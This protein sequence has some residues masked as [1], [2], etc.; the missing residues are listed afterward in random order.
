M[1]QYT[2]EWFPA[3]LRDESGEE[4]ASGR[5]CFNAESRE[6]EFVSDFVPIFPL[7]TAMTIERLYRG[8]AVHIFDGG[9]YLSSRKLMRIV[10]VKDRLCYGAQFVYCTDLDL[11]AELTLTSDPPPKKGFHLFKHAPV[12]PGLR[13]EHVT[14]TAINHERL[15]LLYGMFEPLGRSRDVTIRLL[16]PAPAFSAALEIE[17]EF[18]FGP[19]ASYSCAISSV[20]SGSVDEVG[21]YVYDRYPLDPATLSERRS[22][23]EVSSAGLSLSQGSP[24]VRD[25]SSSFEMLDI[26]NALEEKSAKL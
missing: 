26:P 3:L 20:T 9:V 5:A 22:P 2:L 17:D 18:L 16:P 19:R 11:P 7:G 8:G 24:T 4:L 21:R 13:V 6:V 23:L 14:V 25:E 12:E 10:S 1:L 15:T